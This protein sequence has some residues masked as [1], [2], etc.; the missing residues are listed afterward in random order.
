MLNKPRIR[1]QSAG[2]TASFLSLGP[3]HTLLFV[4][5]SAPLRTEFWFHFQSDP[6]RSFQAGERKA[7]VLQARN[8]GQTGERAGVSKPSFFQKL[9]ILPDQ[10]YESYLLLLY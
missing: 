7:S 3:Q 1:V 4:T 2:F 5:S 10:K 6:S 8:G 9:Q